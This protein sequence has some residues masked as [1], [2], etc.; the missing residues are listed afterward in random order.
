[1]Y[2]R[3]RG[4]WMNFELRDP[5]AKTVRLS[6][7]CISTSS[8]SAGHF[9]TVS[10]TGKITGINDKVTTSPQTVRDGSSRDPE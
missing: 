1:M 8:E 2:S 10:S 3:K 6:S 5:Q 9:T 4:A 7:T